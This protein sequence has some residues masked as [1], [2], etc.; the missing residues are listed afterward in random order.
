MIKVLATN[1]LLFK[2]VLASE[3]NKDIL[4][5]FIQDFFDIIPEEIIIHNPYSIHDYKEIIE[6]EEITVLRETMRDIS[7]SLKVADITMEL[8]VKQTQFFEERSLYYPFERYCQN[9]N[10]FTNSDQDEKGKCNRYST[11]K[12]VYTLNIL[13]YKHFNDEKSLRVF[14][15]Y[16]PIRKKSF[17]KDLIKIGYFELPKE[18]VE[19]DNQNFWREYFL[20]G[21]V[22]QSAP[23][24]IK[25]AATIIDYV[26]LSKE[27]QTVTDALEKARATY[28]AQLLYA[29]EKGEERGKI[30]GKEIGQ[31]IGNELGEENFAKLIKCL[32]EAKRVDEITMCANDKEYRKA[33]MEEFGIK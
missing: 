4:A 9:Y 22:S 29:E 30:I 18:S 5:G 13:G 1:D 23:E 11:L 2:K 28:D 12:P 27:E 32:T 14:Q 8:Q 10:S 6:N 16:D 31:K 7:V 21:T 33:C 17:E 26:N 24:Y 20:T 15:L 3:E 19:T 25:K